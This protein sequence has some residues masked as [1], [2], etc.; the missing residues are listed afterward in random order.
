MSDVSEFSSGLN[1]MWG[2][3]GWRWELSPQDSRFGEHS[4]FIID[5]G[6]SMKYERQTTGVL[7]W[8]RGAEEF[9]IITIIHISRVLLCQL[10]T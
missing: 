5:V 2:N 9:I 7:L 4:D 3:L 6:Q 1:E 8:W 10:P